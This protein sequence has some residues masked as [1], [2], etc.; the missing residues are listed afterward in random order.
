MYWCKNIYHTLF[1]A[2]IALTLLLPAC[3]PAI[4]EDAAAAKY[5]DLKAY[6]KADSGRL[7]KLN[8][9]ILKTVTHNGVTERKEVKIDD[10]AREL[11]LFSQSD[12]NKPAWRDS[13]TIKTTP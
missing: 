13:Y 4:K 6:F 7:S 3:K 1:A 8:K 2:G 12:I 5:F 9:P 11:S 10:W